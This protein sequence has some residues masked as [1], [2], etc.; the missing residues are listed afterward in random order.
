MPT[1]RYRPRAGADVG[2]EHADLSAGSCLALDQRVVDRYFGSLMHADDHFRALT[3][4]AI[5]AQCPV[6]LDCLT[7]ALAREAG[8]S[9][10][11]GGQPRYALVALR[12]QRERERVPARDLARR[13]IA[14]QRV[15]A[16][17]ASRFHTLRAGEFAT[18]TPML[19]EEE[20]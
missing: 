8:P 15:L 10:A 14:R 12:W 1:P 7:D 11:R 16:G 17:A 13:V 19:D 4:Q 3:A 9:M 6:Q 2:R 20:N 5:C 18:V